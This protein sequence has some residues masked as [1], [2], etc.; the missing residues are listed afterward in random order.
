MVNKFII[1]NIFS[2]FICPRVIINDGESHFTNSHFRNLLKKYGVHHCVT[3]PYHPQ[4]KWPSRS[5]Q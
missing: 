4:G 1:S 3:T 5:Q 2:Q